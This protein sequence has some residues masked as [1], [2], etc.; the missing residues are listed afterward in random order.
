MNHLI[1]KFIIKFVIDLFQ[2]PD[3]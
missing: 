2:L 1:I 3:D